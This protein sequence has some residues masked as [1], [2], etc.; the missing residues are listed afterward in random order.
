[1]SV[2][3]FAKKQL[4]QHWLEDTFSLEEMCEAADIRLGDNVLEIGPG[5][6]T[7][8]RHLLA[9]GAEVI[10][11]EYDTELAQTLR[12]RMGETT[13]SHLKIIEADILS[14]DLR[15]L[16][17]NYKVAANIPYYLTSKLLRVLCESVNPPQKMALL[18]QKEVAERVSALQGDMS[19][20]SVSVQ[21]YYEA[22]AGT[23]VP[24][25]LFTPPPK[26]DSQILELT[27]HEFPLF[28]DLN[29]QLYFR[30]V[31]AG[32][33]NRRKTLLN[34]LSGGLHIEKATV[35]SLLEAAGI[36]DG[37]RAQELSLEDWYRLYKIYGE[38]N[39]A[40]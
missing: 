34:A 7:L 35:H 4:G 36:N 37:T 2:L 24:A 26:V 32:F 28:P 18:V 39:E 21:L 25:A 6:G 16:P 13:D 38:T 22:V 20:L 9:R 19:I 17:A 27:R 29:E 5:A 12:Q 31:K 40:K 11:V 14:F 8:T 3:P 15:T 23:L 33:S 10:A 30:I 1:M